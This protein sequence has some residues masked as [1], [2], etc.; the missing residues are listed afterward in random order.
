MPLTWA[1]LPFQNVPTP[2]S[3]DQKGL[4]NMAAPVVLGERARSIE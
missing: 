4:W 1:A 2:C 3:D